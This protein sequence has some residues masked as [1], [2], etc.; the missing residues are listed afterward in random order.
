MESGR[1]L[2]LTV[3]DGTRQTCT[4]NP[5]YWTFEPALAFSAATL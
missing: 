5:D 2:V 4:P 3:P 1:R